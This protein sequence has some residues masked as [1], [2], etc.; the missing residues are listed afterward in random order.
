MGI[1]LYSKEEKT[2]NISKSTH[3]VEKLFMVFLHDDDVIMLIIECSQDSI[4][5]RSQS[6]LHHRRRQSPNQLPNT[7]MV[8]K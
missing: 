6:T 3:G 4:L 7:A 8:H 5:L 2:D 1:V